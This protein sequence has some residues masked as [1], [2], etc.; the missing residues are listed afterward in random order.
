MCSAHNL[1]WEEGGA[2]KYQFLIRQRGVRVRDF[3]TMTVM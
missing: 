1:G 2:C 3:I